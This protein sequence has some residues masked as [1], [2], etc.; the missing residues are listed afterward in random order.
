VSF[1]RVA[2]L[3]APRIVVRGRILKSGMTGWNLAFF[4]LRH[5]LFRRND[6]KLIFYAVIKFR[7]FCF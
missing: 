1:H 4:E 3:D 2:L 5:S 6:K 7:I